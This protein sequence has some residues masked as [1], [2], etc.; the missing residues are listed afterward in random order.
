MK[1]NIPSLMEKRLFGVE[2]LSREENRI[3]NCLKMK[4]VNDGTVHWIHRHILMEWMGFQTRHPI[5]QALNETIE[6]DQW[7]SEN[8]GGKSSEDIG[9]KR[10]GA[11][12]LCRPCEQ[13]WQLLAGSWHFRLWSDLMICHLAQIE[14]V[15][16]AEKNFQDEEDYDEEC[17]F[18]DICN[19][20]NLPV[21]HCG[22]HCAQASRSS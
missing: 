5:A 14:C 16:K 1:S 3:L 7:I 19:F 8:T 22:A 13:I 9:G 17:D 6:C 11:T 18:Y 12:R 21:H 20:K 4:G 10:C 15:M 2:V